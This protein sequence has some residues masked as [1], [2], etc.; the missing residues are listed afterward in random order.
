M[1]YSQNEILAEITKNFAVIS[2]VT[3]SIF[4]ANRNC[5]VSGSDNIPF[6]EAVRKRPEL[7]KKCHECDKIGFKGCSATKKPYLYHCH[8]GLVE[9]TAPIMF[10]DTLIGYIIIGQFADQPDKS[11]IKKAV[12]D[13]ANKYGFNADNLLT[14]VDEIPC[15]GDAYINALSQL[16]E[17]C[18]GYIW[19]KNVL[20]LSESDLAMEIR[21]YIVGHLCEDLSVDALCNKYGLSQTALYQLFKKSFGVSVVQIIRLERVN[22]AKELLSEAKFSIG[23]VAQQVGIPD[24][25]YFTRTFKAITGKTPKEY[26]KS[27]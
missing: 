2:N 12:A 21:L 13:T 19:L 11:E 18:A 4:D 17:M 14:Y 15:P 22:K 5:V 25:N 16:V 1:P 10:G 20:K 7:H 26:A 3:V 27:F 8:M 23:E 24:A 6:C 9:I